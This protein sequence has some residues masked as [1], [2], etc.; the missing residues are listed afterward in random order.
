[1]PPRAIWKGAISFGMVVIPVRLYAG[2]ESRDIRFSNL[3]ANVPQPASAEAL[4]PLS[5]DRG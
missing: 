2:T 4:V 5:R 3:H 1:M